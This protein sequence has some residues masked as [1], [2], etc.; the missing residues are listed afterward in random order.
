MNRYASNEPME[1]QVCNTEGPIY[2]YDGETPVLERYTVYGYEIMPHDVLTAG[3]KDNTIV[4]RPLGT[5]RVGE[6]V[7]LSLDA[8]NWD[9]S[10]PLPQILIEWIQNA[11]A[12]GQPQL[13]LAQ[14][15]VKGMYAYRAFCAE[16]DE[17]EAQE[18]REAQQRKDEL[19]RQQEEEAK[20]Q[21]ARLRDADLSVAPVKP[22]SRPGD[23]IEV[24]EPPAWEP[25]PF[26]YIDAVKALADSYPTEFSMSHSSLP[27]HSSLAQ[28]LW[29]AN[30]EGK[31]SIHEVGIQLD[32]ALRSF[33]VEGRL[34]SVAFDVDPGDKKLRTDRWAL[35]LACREQSSRRRH[36]HRVHVTPGLFEPQLRITGRKV[37]AHEINAIEYVGNCIMQMLL[38]P[39]RA[40]K[41]QKPY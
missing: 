41:V 4:I 34:T 38:I 37:Y 9:E 32:I 1:G 8:M 30:A 25:P 19:A 40:P 15:W 10:Q 14:Q 18:A 20:Q 27:E 24:P 36:I 31:L 7:E 17:R 23:F 29:L 26:Y 11:D 3:G 28:L 13:A 6:S 21:S 39:A 2:D 35:S 16:R 22:G 5:G 33:D 12:A